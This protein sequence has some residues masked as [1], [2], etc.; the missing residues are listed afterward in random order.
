MSKGRRTI[1][2]RIGLRAGTAAARVSFGAAVAWSISSI[3]PALAQGDANQPSSD[4]LT[5][6][7]A[8]SD[9]PDP[10]FFTG[11]FG[12]SR[13]NLLGDMGG[14][15]TALG[16]HGISLDAVETSELFG[17]VS[18][19]V[20]RGF[21]YDGLTTATLGIDTDKAFGW[22][23]GQFNVSALQIHG[24]NLS[25]DNL[26]NLQT[27]SGIESSRATR[28][29]ELWYQQ[30]F[31]GGDADVKIGQQSVD[32]EF[33]GSQYSALFVNTMM[34]WPMLPS[35]DL[36]AGGPAYPLSSPGIRLRA[37]PTKSLT[38]LA[39]V[40]DDNPPGGPFSG[41]PQTLGAEKSGT[42]FNLNTGALVLGEIQY[43]V[44]Q[45]ALG[46]MAT[47]DQKTGLPGTYKLGFWYDTAAFPD[48]R[49][50]TAGVSLASLAT[51]GNP[52]SDR[53]NFS[54]YGVFDQ[55]VLQT[56][57][58]DPQSVGIFARAMGSP[59]DRNLIDFS[60]N[61]GVNLK[62]PFA[63]R[64]DDTFGVGYGLAKVGSGASGLDRDTNA[65]GGGPIPVRSLEHFIEVTYQYQVAQWWQVQPDFQYVFNPG[66]GVVNPNNAAQRLG[67][68]AI[69]GVR[70]NIT[71]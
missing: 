10:G 4:K 8:A 63:G 3:S 45:P 15:R 40:F 28:L 69:I 50:D 39:G 19:G 70:T 51:N 68:E 60:L 22:E 46:D 34:G 16:N 18:G 48:Q 55:T 67:D 26:A 23:G 17:N 61:T 43:A 36:Y 47:V 49:Y 59:G 65:F 12:E 42:K 54:I 33:M 57:P 20:R 44:N 41:D 32:Q 13:G 14:L 31:L 30:E 62:A 5:A 37:H 52:R 24:R 58:N 1:G 38:V 6:A 56:D 2:R 11:L 9:A 7:P 29:W 64:D 71:F 35:A 53:G 21:E 27:A 25:A 66:A